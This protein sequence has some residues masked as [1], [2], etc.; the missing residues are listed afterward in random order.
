MWKTDKWKWA[1]TYSQSKVENKLTL[2]GW[3]NNSKKGDE[4]GPN[5]L[6]KGT[7]DNTDTNTKNISIKS[8]QGNKINKYTNINNQDN[9]DE[10]INNINI[11]DWKGYNT[12]LLWKE[13]NWIYHKKLKL[14]KEI[15]FS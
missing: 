2:K 9:F 3:N 10:E 6:M 12:K 13:K 14:L 8:N 4:N 5:K 11:G 7:N 1:N 15:I